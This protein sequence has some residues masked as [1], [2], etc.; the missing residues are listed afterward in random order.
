MILNILVAKTELITENQGTPMFFS[1]FHFL[2]LLTN[3]PPIKKKLKIYL[4]PDRSRSNPSFIFSKG[5]TWVI[6]A[7]NGNFLTIKSSTSLGTDSL[8]LKPEKKTSLLNAA[9]LSGE[10]ERRFSK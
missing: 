3:P 9:G 1:Y 7:S 6:N 8:L 10:L 4:L 5:K 2:S